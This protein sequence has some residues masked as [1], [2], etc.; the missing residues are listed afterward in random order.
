MSFELFFGMRYLRAK[1]KQAFISV[2]T[3]I[4]VV[5]V[6]VGVMSLI[7]VISV[8]NGFTAD[9]ISKILGVNAHIQVQ[10]Y[11]GPFEDHEQ[12]MEDINNI[13]GVISTTPF[14]FSQ[15]MINFKGRASGAFLTGLD[16][17]TAGEV[18]KIAPMI[19]RG[20]LSSLDE[21]YNGTPG[22]IVGE[23]LA[24]QIGAIPGDIVTIISPQGRLTPAGRAPSSRKFRIVGLYNSGMYDYD[25]LLAYIPLDEAQDFLGIKG[26]IMSI[27][28]RAQDAFESDGI[29][30]IIK[31]ML[32]Y[33]FWV[34][35]WKVRNRSLLSALKLE[36]IV[37][38]IILII[39]ILVG[40]L[41]IISTLVMV[42]IEKTRDVAIL[43]AMGATSKSIMK[44]FM[45]Q[46]LMV[47]LVG[48]LA[49]LIS[50]LGIC[51]LISKYIHID[52]PT[53]F[54]GLTTLPV[55]VE[56]LDVFLVTLAAFLISFMAT[57]YPSWYASRLNPVEA[58]RYE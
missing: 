5:G 28:V 49:G 44:I 48:T 20:S 11:A 10:S 58:L 37:M 24:R 56:A 57:V 12:I 31:T 40:A 15:V 19:R 16:G 9:L 47:G 38:F 7:V 29:G 54:Y 23:V 6:M 14:I 50:G 39:I 53:D 43:R 34:Q 46:G 35:D 55:K 25:S 18:I 52:I 21:D 17:D 2:S 4:S 8:M 26:R 1:R 30:E 45:L 51:H 3:I 27:G 32:G 41:N 36:K 33:P 13:D 42:V 22:V